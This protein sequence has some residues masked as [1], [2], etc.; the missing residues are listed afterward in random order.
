M[1]LHRE[2]TPKAIYRLG[3]RVPGGRATYPL[4]Y[5]S[6]T[7]LSLTP[8]DL[9]MPTIE[10][11]KGFGSND[12]IMQKVYFSQLTRV[13]VGFNN[14]SGVYLTQVSLLFIGQQCLE[15]FFRYRPMLPIGSRIVQIVRQPRRKTKNTA[16][17]AASQST[18]INELLFSTCD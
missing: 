6:A 7:N 17:L 12:F 3:A 16:I 9:P 11:P 13:C 5:S 2:T 14:V 15:D 18:F 8:S 1:I 10:V 4:L